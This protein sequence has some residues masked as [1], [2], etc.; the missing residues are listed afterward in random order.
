MIH[1]EFREK[2]FEDPASWPMCPL[3]GVRSGMQDANHWNVFKCI[4]C[5]VEFVVGAGP[6][7]HEMKLVKDKGKK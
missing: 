6:I 2:D 5:E 4:H 1:Q 3:C 7:P